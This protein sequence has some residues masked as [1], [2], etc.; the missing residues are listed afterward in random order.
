VNAIGQSALSEAS[1]P[2]TPVGPADT[3][4]PTA[5]VLP[6]AN[7]TGVAVGANV[8]ATFDEPVTGVNDATFFLRAAGGTTNIA[9]TVAYDATTRVATLNPTANLA[10]GTTYTASMSNGIQDLASPANS[11]T[12]MTWSFTTAGVAN[13]A[14]TIT[15]RTPGQDATSIGAAANITATFSE[16]VQGVSTATFAVRPAATPNA[17]PI[18]ATVTRNGTTNQWILNPA[19]NLARDTRYTVTLT[20]GSTAIRDTQGAALATTSWSFITGPAP[21]VTARTPGVNANGVNRTA[22]V[23]AT[24][25]ENVQA[26][27]GTT[28]TLRNIA[29]NALVTAAVSYNATSRVVTLNPSATLPAR[30]QFRV[31]LSGGATAIRDIAGNPLA[32][33]TWTFTTGA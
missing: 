32:D 28:V 30:T 20:G 29:T 15:G 24:F 17:A 2:V 33:V 27:S 7:A 4:A 12:A 18:A 14:P 1:A 10:A 21:T 6:A 8:T 16:A 13:Q 9:A 11:L 23:T 3:T 5:S 19:A 31:S 26:A 25:S 22:N